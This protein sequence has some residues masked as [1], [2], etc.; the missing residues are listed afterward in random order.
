[1]DEGAPG[2]QAAAQAPTEIPEGTTGE[3]DFRGWVPGSPAVGWEHM[4]FCPSPNEVGMQVD[5]SLP[6]SRVVLS[7]MPCC[8]HGC[9]PISWRIENLL[10]SFQPLLSLS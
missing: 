7:L 2:E 10:D 8:L 5:A 3:G 1:M 6:K 4:G 9:L